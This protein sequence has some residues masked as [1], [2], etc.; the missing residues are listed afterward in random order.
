MGVFSVAVIAL[1][2]FVAAMVLLKAQQSDQERRMERFCNSASR[3]SLQFHA[4]DGE[5]KLLHHC[6]CHYKVRYGKEPHWCRVCADAELE[7][8]AHQEFI[9]ERSRVYGTNN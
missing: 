9:R 7:R 8:R 5:G 6:Q 4:Y 3:H 1:V 2:V